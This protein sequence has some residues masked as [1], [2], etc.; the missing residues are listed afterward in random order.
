MLSRMM[1]ANRRRI[2]RNA[3]EER[4]LQPGCLAAN[5]RPHPGPCAAR[6][7]RRHGRE[8]LLLR[9]LGASDA[10]H[11]SELRVANCAAPVRKRKLNRN[12]PCFTPGAEPAFSIQKCFSSSSTGSFTFYRILSAIPPSWHKRSLWSTSFLDPSKQIS[13]H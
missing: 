8:R 5:K 12:S 13:T 2:N 6:L 4:L 1:M 9:R 3:G 10:W 7:M 11:K